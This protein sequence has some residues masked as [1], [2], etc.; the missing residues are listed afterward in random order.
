MMFWKNRNSGSLMIVALIGVLSA[1][2][3]WSCYPDSGLTSAGDFDLI[4]T[5]YDPDKDFSGFVTYFLLDS[6]EHIIPE[7]EEDNITREY[8]QQILDRVAKNLNDLNYQRIVDTTGVGLPEL[9]I[10]VSVTTSTYKGWTWYPGW[11][12]GWYP[13]YPW[14]PGYVVPTE[15]STGTVLIDMYD[16]EEYIPGPDVAP[17]IWVAGIDGLLGDSKTNIE[18]RLDRNIDQSFNQSP[19]LGR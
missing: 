19:Y 17:A 8:D 1:I 16:V 18:F 10:K 12:G 9:G 2:S 5:Q 13:W 6:I 14:Y 7:G 3:I 4:V 15:F 11:W